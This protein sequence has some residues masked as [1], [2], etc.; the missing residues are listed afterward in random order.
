MISSVCILPFPASRT[1]LF[2]RSWDEYIYDGAS[3]SYW[4]VAFSAPYHY[5]EQMTHRHFNSQFKFVFKQM[6]I[7]KL[8][9]F[10]FRLSL[11]IAFGNSFSFNFTNV[12]NTTEP[13]RHNNITW[14]NVTSS[15]MTIY[16]HC[17]DA[18]MSAMVSQITGVSI[19]CSTVCWGTDQ[20]KHQSSASL[21]FV[22]GATSDRWIQLT[23]ASNAEN[24]SIWRRHHHS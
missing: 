16:V 7:V 1:L 21:A 24:A 6:F 14:T 18:I 15:A 11:C 5:L 13:W 2:L 4:I 22:K 19:V 3:G 8:S 17:N 20:R 10:R 23:R 12:Y 9:S